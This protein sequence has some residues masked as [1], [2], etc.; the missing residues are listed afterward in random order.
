VAVPGSGPFPFSASVTTT[1]ATEETTD[2]PVI[3]NYKGVP[4]MKSVWFNFTPDASAVYQIDTLGSTPAN[5]YDTIIGLYTGACGNLVPLANGCA[6]DSTGSLQ[7]ILTL[8][9]EGGKTYTIVVSGLGIRD[10]F[11]PANSLPSNGGELKLN[12]KRVSVSY[13]YRYMIPSVAKAPGAGDSSF[14]S[15]VTVAN[16]DKD[17]GFLFF[18]FLG[19]GKFRDENPPANQPVS[20]PVSLAAGG[21]RDFP[22]ILGGLNV[23]ND[24]G[25]LLIQSSRKLFAGS[26][27]YTPSAGGGS[28]GQYTQAVDLS[29]EL[30]TVG[31]VG[32]FISVREDDRFR[33]NLA[34][35]N[36]ASVQCVI[37]VEVHDSLGNPFDSGTRLPVLPPN[38]M[39]QIS[40]LKEYF[41]FSADVVNATVVVSVQTPCAVGGAAYVIDRVTNDPYAVSLR[42]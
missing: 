26:R 5:D 15:D 1:G 2:P 31:E 10:A 4:A 32:R 23:S 13:P 21:A 7:S 8:A 35:F 40:G 39:V 27:T 24:Y 20:T 18:Q 11:D 25:A 28:F 17:D 12:V 36:T 34:F 29:T 33:T 14:V 37:R 30:L 3:C 38:T 22:D 19:H 42:K 41:G 9:L 16:V 6:D